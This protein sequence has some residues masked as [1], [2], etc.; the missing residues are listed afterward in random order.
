[1]PPNQAPQL[2]AGT[3][4]IRDH[5]AEEIKRLSVEF[6]RPPV[7]GLEPEWHFLRG[8]WRITKTWLTPT[9]RGNENRGIRLSTNGHSV[10]FE[11]WC[12]P[13]RLTLEWYEMVPVQRLTAVINAA[14]GLPG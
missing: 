12:A 14:F 2:P 5:L 4:E 10:R 6:G 3:D 7:R 8:E 13:G 11:A 9:D 1:M